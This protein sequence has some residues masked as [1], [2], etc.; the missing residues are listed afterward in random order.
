MKEHLHKF[1][2][3]DVSGKLFGE[4]ECWLFV[5]LKCSYRFKDGIC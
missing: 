4:T 3:V 2:S 5:F 1:S